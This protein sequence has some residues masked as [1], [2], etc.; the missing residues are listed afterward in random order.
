MVE[1]DRVVL[2]IDGAAQATLGGKRVVLVRHGPDETNVLRN[3]GWDIDS[4][5]LHAERVYRG[6]FT[7]FAHQLATVAFMVQ[8]ERG[9]VLNSLGSG[10]S[11]AAIW[12]CKLLRR[13]R[14]LKMSRGIRAALVVAPLSTLRDVWEKEIRRLDPGARVQVLHGT[15]RKRLAA[16][17]Q[18]AEYYIINH[19]GVK[20]L[21][22]E[23]ASHWLIDAV[24]IDE[25]TAF[26]NTRT[27]RWRSMNAIVNDQKHQRRCWALT[28]TPMAQSPLDVYGQ[29]RLVRPDKVPRYMSTFRDALMFQV[30]PHVWVPKAGYLEIVRDTMQPAIR[31]AKED[32]VSLPPITYVDRMADKTKEQKKAEEALLKEWMAVK[33]EQTITAANAAVKMNK[34]LQVYQ[35]VVLDDQKEPVVLDAAP[36]HALVLELIEEAEHDV[37]VFVPYRG[38][39]DKLS[40]TLE[41]AGVEHVVVHGGVGSK[42]RDKRF[43]AFREGDARV[44]LAHP[45]TTSHGLSFTNADVTIWY[46]PVTSVET[47]LQANQR[48]ARPGQKHKMTIFHAAADNLERRLFNRLREGADV[49]EE[50]LASY[51]ELMR[52]GDDD[53]QQTGGSGPGVPGS[54]MHQG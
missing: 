39:L 32:C 17:G 23:L 50:L 14:E 16:L 8:N 43:K 37:I 38:V 6:P 22:K 11:A 18:D 40:E 33:G 51:R 47:Y 53:E 46:G 19:D 15:K 20:V 1:L 21:R 34:L 48:M 2:T 52:C 13:C 30:S 54:E 9:F 49:Q 25:A 45:R 35:G 12:A 42:E 31:V 5:A 44:L 10:K 3:L 28:G 26:K 7:P 4:P 27:D 24:I 29:V 36:R 41:T